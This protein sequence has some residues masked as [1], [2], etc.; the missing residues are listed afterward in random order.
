MRSSDNRCLIVPRRSA[1]KSR[2]LPKQSPKIGGE[3]PMN[4]WS[5]IYLTEH[6]NIGYLNRIQRHRGGTAPHKEVNACPDSHRNDRID[7][8]RMLLDLLSHDQKVLQEI[9]YRKTRSIRADKPQSRPEWSDRGLA[10]KAIQCGSGESNMG[11]YNLYTQ[12][13]RYSFVSKR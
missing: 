10:F 2:A 11:S 8:G 1:H 4:V 5:S 6:L 12:S 9:K 3:W 13:Y 7:H